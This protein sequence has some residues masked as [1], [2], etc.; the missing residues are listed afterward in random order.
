MVCAACWRMA[1]VFA[2]MHFCVCFR[3]CPFPFFNFFL[4]LVSDID[5]LDVMINDIT[6][7]YPY[8]LF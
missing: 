4:L 2:I 8:M 6:S 5:K 3:F 1:L 7:S